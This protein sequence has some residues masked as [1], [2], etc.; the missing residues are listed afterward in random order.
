[1]MVFVAHIL[2]GLEEKKAEENCGR[3]RGPGEIDPR[4][5]GRVCR[6]LYQDTGTRDKLEVDSGRE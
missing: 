3:G 5:D 4:L 6:E 1:M 2:R